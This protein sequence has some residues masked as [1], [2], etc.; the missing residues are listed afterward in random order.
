MVV[1][2]GSVVRQTVGMH[3]ELLGPAVNVAHRLL[4]NEIQARIGRRP[5]LFVSAAAAQG[6]GVPDV[7]L[8]HSETYA[9][10]GT[11]EGRIIELGGA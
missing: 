7:G 11:I 4:K 2:R 9:D 8:E 10:V 1:H 3:T 6:L 5:Y